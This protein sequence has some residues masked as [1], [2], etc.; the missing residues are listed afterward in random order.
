MRKVAYIAPV[1]FGLVAE[2]LHACAQH[3]R[4][5]VL[6]KIVGRSLGYHIKHVRLYYVYARIHKVAEYLRGGRLFYKA[7]YKAVLVL[8]HNAVF[9]RH[10]YFF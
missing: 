6:G 2:Y 1:A 8:K 9:H 10:F 4:K 7:G 3:A 5:K